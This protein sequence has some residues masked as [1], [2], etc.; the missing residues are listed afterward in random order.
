ML[1]HFCSKVANLIALFH[2]YFSTTRNEYVNA[3]LVPKGGQVL[4]HVKNFCA[5]AIFP[6]FS[7]SILLS[8]T[9]YTFRPPRAK[10][11]GTC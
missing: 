5:H 7:T 9:V 4:L 10:A 11:R 8:M 2:F 6:V 3:I 1:H